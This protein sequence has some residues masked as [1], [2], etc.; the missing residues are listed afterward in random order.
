MTPD[1]KAICDLLRGQ[2]PI[3]SRSEVADAI[4]AI[5]A[6]LTAER[7][8][9]QAVTVEVCAVALVKTLGMTVTG[10]QKAIRALATSPPHVA[11][12]RVLLVFLD[13]IG[14]NLKPDVRGL[15]RAIATQGGE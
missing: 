14:A 5:V 15:I 8:A 3:P 1:P 12:A 9:V 11:A 6:H 10:Q 2:D 4:E 13:D 7:D